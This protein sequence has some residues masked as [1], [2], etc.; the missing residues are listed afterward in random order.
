MQDM[1]ANS[2]GTATSSIATGLDEKE[3]RQRDRASFFKNSLPLPSIQSQRA[4][5]ERAVKRAKDVLGSA[6]DD[7][8]L[9]RPPVR[10]DAR[11]SSYACPIMSEV[12]EPNIAEASV[13]LPQAMHG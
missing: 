6:M 11:L 2:T 13:Y 12:F 9:T 4:V 10:F 3:D 1:P 8:G 7:L 5:A